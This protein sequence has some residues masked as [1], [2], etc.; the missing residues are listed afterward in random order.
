MLE[1]WNKKA[2]PLYL[3]SRVDCAEK[4]RQI[5]LLQGHIKDPTSNMMHS[6]LKHE[7]PLNQIHP[8]FESQ[9][10]PYNSKAVQVGDCA[11]KCLEIAPQSGQGQAYHT[12]LPLLHQERQISSHSQIETASIPLNPEAVQVSPLLC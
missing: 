1:G 11:E 5:A 4:H 9:G 12:A 8:G 2:P 3:W 6:L 7:V 10:T